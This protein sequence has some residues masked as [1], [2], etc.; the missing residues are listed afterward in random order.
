MKEFIITG[1]ES[2]LLPKAYNWKLV[3]HDEFDGTELDRGKWDFRLNFWGKRF[4][5]YT[6]KGIILDGKSNV[7]IHLLEKDGQFYSAQLQTGSNSFDLPNRYQ[8]I[9]N[10]S[11][12]PGV[13]NEIWPL[14]ELSKPKF[15]HRYGYYEVRCKLQ[16]QPGWWS[17]F[18][19]QSPSIGTAYDPSYSGIECD[20]MENFTRDG[21]V[22]SGNIFGGYGSQRK[23]DARIRYPI[24]E[25]EDGF[26]RFG[27][28]WSKEGY[29]FYCDGRET[30]RT[31]KYVSKVEQFILLTTECK[32]YRKGNGRTPDDKL[33]AAV[34]PDCFT[35]DYVR[36]FDEL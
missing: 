5:T 33:L 35:V 9:A 25:S 2:S 6:D 34:L 18:W 8:Q 12:V 23:S 10:A 13:E 32:G 24:G 17:A 14:G 30:T 3:W 29:V 26:H 15:M 27:V 20:I 4:Q 1:H 31:N 36:V 22:T 19:L 7:E 16:K 21:E 11:N 28:H